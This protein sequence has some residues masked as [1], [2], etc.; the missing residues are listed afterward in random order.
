M[1]LDE[2]FGTFSRTKLI[3]MIREDGSLIGER[4]CQGRK[5]YIYM[6]KDFFVQ[7]KFQK[8]DPTEDV[9]F[10]ETFPDLH[11]LNS[12]LENEFRAAF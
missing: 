2:I 4:Q 3:K 11:K 6:L 12:H 7:V 8:D 10:V 1:W 5:I 9:E